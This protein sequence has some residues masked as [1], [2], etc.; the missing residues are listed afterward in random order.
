MTLDKV[1]VIIPNFNNEKWLSIC[2]E[3]C[4]QQEGEFEI[5]IIIVDDHSTDGSWELLKKYQLENQGVIFIYRNPS[6]G[7]NEARNYGFSKS[8]GNFIQ[9][10]DSDDFL[11]KGKLEN[12]L[13]YLNADNNVEV[14][15][16]DWRMDFY[17]EGKKHKEEIH[18]SKATDFYLEALI[19]EDW[20]PNLSYLMRRTV[21]Q[22]LHEKLGW[23]PKRKVGQDRE[24]FNLAAIYGASFAYVPGLF[25]VYN[26]WSTKS[27]SKI[28][29][30]ERLQLSM[31]LDDRLIN[32]IESQEWLSNSQKKRLLAILKTYALKS[33]YYRPNLR[34]LHPLAFG[35][36][37][38]GVIHYKMRPIIP[39]IWMYQMILYYLRNMFDHQH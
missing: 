23:N 36:I 26:R 11:L 6:K 16:S 32:E 21:A 31:D 3:S 15:Y 22:R 13:K 1:S 17:E 27:V 10:L 4:L 38:W 37:Q 2:I 20:Q 39:F 24:Y 28:D 8:T 5:E 18:L 19:L 33:C 7:G 34:I 30:H 25:S 14:V 12:Q 9:W 35:Q 29:Y